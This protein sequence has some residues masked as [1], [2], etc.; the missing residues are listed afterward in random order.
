[1]HRVNVAILGATGLVGQELLGI[2]EERA[3]PVG[4]LRLAGSDRS[5]GQ[6]VRA[7]GREVV[8]SRPDL[9][10]FQGMDIAFSAVQSDVARSLA[11]LAREA[12]CIMI[13]KSSAF[14][15]DPAVPLVVPEVNPHALLGHEG[16]VASPNCSTTQLVVALHPLRSLGPITHVD[17]ST[18][19]AVS[20]T[21]RD[22]VQEMEAQMRGSASPPKV[23]PKRILGNVLPQVDSFDEN[24]YSVEE[25]KLIRETRKI[26]EAPDL[27]LTA[28][29]VR[30]PVFRGHGEAVSVQF[31]DEIDVADARE[32]LGKASGVRVLDLPDVPT[33]LDADGN[34]WVWVGRLR[35]DLSTPRGLHFFVVSDNLRKGA[36]TNA[37][38]IAERLLGFKG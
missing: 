28:T 1:M 24:G 26:L 3:F 15:M 17:V 18:Y 29:A 5:I 2:L 12:G 4:E 7:L 16:V 35:K 9:A 36:A 38:Q 14:R 32:A 23:Y 27:Q 30:V 34:D 13:D 22:A 37:V 8:L 31:E 6:R 20:G 25:L 19:Q 10:F 11:P 21:G 33:S